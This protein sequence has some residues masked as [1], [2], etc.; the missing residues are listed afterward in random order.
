MTRREVAELLRVSEKTV[1][2]FAAREGLLRP[3]RLP[4]A[5]GRGRMRFDA[6]DVYALLDALAQAS[7]KS[8]TRRTPLPTSPSP[9]DQPL[10][11]A[12]KAARLRAVRA[13]MQTN[14]TAA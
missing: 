3:I 13:A 11:A 6:A 1:S 5:S 4:G 7:P 10:I 14:T 2:K 8:R 12:R 9:S